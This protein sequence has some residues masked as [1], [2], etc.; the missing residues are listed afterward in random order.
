MI[1]DIL[2]EFDAPATALTAT[3]VSTNVIDTRG[4]ADIGIGADIFLYVQ[5]NTALTSAGAST[6]A[7]SIETD[8]NSAFSSAT[9]IYTTVAI[10]KASLVGGYQVV[11][12]PI[13]SGCERYLRLRYTVGTADFTAGTVTAEIIPYQGQ[14]DRYYPSAVPVT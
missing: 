8:D 1:T 6:L 14:S 3:R 5:V 12:T 7:V 10:P 4:V 11:N 13:P 9:T 2:N